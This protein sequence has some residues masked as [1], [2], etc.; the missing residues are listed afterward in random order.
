M[1]RTAAPNCARRVVG[2]H[3]LRRVAAEL[4]AYVGDREEHHGQPLEAEA[5]GPAVAVG[6]ADV[7]EHARVETPQPSTSIQSPL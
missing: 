2:A 6:E 7:L 5:E 3:E 1:S 4:R